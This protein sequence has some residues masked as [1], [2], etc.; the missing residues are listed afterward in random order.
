MDL[1]RF[2]ADRARALDVSGIRK[3][4]DLSA[5]LKD[6]INFSI[7]QPDFDVPDNVKE[8]AIRAIREG[9][10]GYTP[11]QGVEPLRQKLLAALKQEFDWDPLVL[12]TSGVSGGLTLAMLACLNPGDEVIVPDPYFVSYRHLPGMLGAKAVV[13]D[14]YPDF[15]LLPERI[16]AAITPR[17]KMLLFSSP[18]N[19]T[20]VVLPE[21]DLRAVAELARKHDLL[22]LADEIYTALSYDGPAPSVVRFAPERTVLLRGFGKSHGMTGWRLGYAAGPPAIVGEMTKLQQYTFVLAPSCVQWAAVEALDTPATPRVEE[23]R[24]KRDLVCELLGGT[25]EFARPSGSFYVFPHVPSAYAN[26]TDF[27]TAGMER[28]VLTIPGKFFSEVDTHFRLSY[29]APNDKIRA[30]CK[31]LCAM[32]RG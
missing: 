32:A 29:A 26:S 6:P 2:I 20:G 14:T 5:T 16:E 30:G 28:N 31:I 9:K 12:V 11:T 19:P 4:F 13:V 8:A 7:G 18:S 10:N 21:E 15:R 3:M 27:V 25:F 23:Y 1:N 17:T 22:L 24:T